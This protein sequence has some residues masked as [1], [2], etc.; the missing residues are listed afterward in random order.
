[1]KC[2]FISGKVRSLKY[3]LPFNLKAAV[4]FDSLSFKRE[5]GYF[6]SLNYN[7]LVVL[8]TFKW[9]ETSLFFISLLSITRLTDFNES[10]TKNY[11]LEKYVPVSGAV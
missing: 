4:N 5:I 3:S 9:V 7:K 1:M 11:K 2:I 6:L 10:G 8:S